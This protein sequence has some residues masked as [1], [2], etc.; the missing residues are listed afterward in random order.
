[1]PEPPP[2]TNDVIME[3][4]R[5]KSAVKLAETSLITE[6][7]VAANIALVGDGISNDVV[8]RQVVLVALAFVYPQAK[9]PE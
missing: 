6:Q 2:L 7:D 3:A 4:L 9:Q 1:M 5:I 8:R